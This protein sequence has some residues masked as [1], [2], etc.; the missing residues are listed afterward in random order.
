MLP[1]GRVLYIYHEYWLVGSQLNFDDHHV[2]VEA[3][4]VSRYN[5]HVVP[6]AGVGYHSGD[7][8]R[9]WCP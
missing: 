1:D 4:V 6:L 5:D 2:V 8:V 3:Y 7:S 9:W